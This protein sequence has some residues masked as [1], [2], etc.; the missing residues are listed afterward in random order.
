[1]L[2]ENAVIIVDVDEG[3]EPRGGRLHG[4]VPLFR[5]AVGATAARGGVGDAFAVGAGDGGLV[6]EDGGR[7]GAAG[8]EL[9]DIG[10]AVGAKVAEEVEV[11]GVE[12][13]GGAVAGGEGGGEGGH[14]GRGLGALGSRRLCLC[15]AVSPSERLAPAAC[16][17]SASAVTIDD[18]SFFLAGLMGPSQFKYHQICLHRSEC[19][20]RRKLSIANRTETAD[21]KFISMQIKYC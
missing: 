6:L 19:K 16:R 17:V 12:R 14:R 20:Y 3:I 11:V 18:S 8:R 9:E 10:V 4:R 21:Q 5:P 13:T 1:M 7:G 2:Q 15:Q